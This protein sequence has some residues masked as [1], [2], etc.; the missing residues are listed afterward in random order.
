MAVHDDVIKRL[1]IAYRHKKNQIK[2]IALI[3]F[4]VGTGAA[5]SY[6]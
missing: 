6:G 4:H 1:V 2:I 3:S 5:Y